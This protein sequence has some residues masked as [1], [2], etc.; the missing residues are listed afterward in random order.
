MGLSFNEYV[1]RMRIDYA[2]LLL[3]QQPDRPLGEVAEQSG[4]T[5]STSFYRNF[6]LYKGIGPKEYQNKLKGTP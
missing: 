6:R 4:F 1:N 3:S 2:A 5:S